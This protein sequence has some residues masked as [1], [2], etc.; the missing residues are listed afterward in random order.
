M[1]C[2]EQLKVNLTK[3]I[4]CKLETFFVNQTLRYFFLFKYQI[5]DLNLYKTLKHKLLHKNV[6]QYM[7]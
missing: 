6:K 5:Q 1:L 7:I 4:L 3:C 2:Y